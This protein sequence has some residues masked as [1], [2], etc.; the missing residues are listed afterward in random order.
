[1]GTNVE[2]VLKELHDSIQT[3][4][5]TPYILLPAYGTVG[6]RI[7][8]SVEGVNYPTGWVLSIGTNPVDLIITHNQNKRIIDVKIWAVNGTE[9]QQLVGTV[10]HNGLITPNANSLKIQSLATLAKPIRIY[11]IWE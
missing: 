6:D 7:N 5:N 3:A 2:D 4:R 9:E 8:N 10:A 11:I 1:V